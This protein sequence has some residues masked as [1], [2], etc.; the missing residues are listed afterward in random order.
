MDL[1]GATLSWASKEKSSK[2]NVLEV[3][4]DLHQVALTCGRG[5]GLTGSDLL[6]SLLQLKSR[7]GVDFLIQYDT[8]SIISDWFKVLSDTI[9]QLVSR[10]VA[11]FKLKFTVSQLV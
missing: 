11:H 10:F 8:E 2:K 9:R 7:S 1:R 6:C 4:G 5:R 3:N